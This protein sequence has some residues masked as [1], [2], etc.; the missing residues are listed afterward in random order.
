MYTLENPS[1]GS[2]TL[3]VQSTDAKWKLE[4]QGQS[5]VVFTPDSRYAIYK[6]RGD[7][8]A[9]LTLGNGA[10]EYISNA[11]NYQL[12]QKG[13]W[14]VYK[15]SAAEKT[16]VAY[17]LRSK[18]KR[19]FDRVNASWLSDDGETLLLQTSSKDRTHAL[20]VVS[21]K[22]KK[23][24]IIWEGNGIG[25][26]LYDGNEK[27][28]FI[29]D[30][31]QNGNIVK[32]IWDCNLQMEK[33]VP[34][35]QLTVPVL[36][37]DLKVAS[38]DRF[39]QSG[40]RLFIKLRE[41]KPFRPPL[42]PKPDAVKLTVWSYNDAILQSNQVGHSS[43]SSMIAGRNEEFLGVVD[44]EE[45]TLTRLE[46][47]SGE[48]TTSAT[49]EVFLTNGLKKGGDTFEQSWNAAIT[50]P[51]FLVFARDGE[52]KELKGFEEM[53]RPDISPA[54]K[55][56][57]YWNSRE[58]NFFTYEIATGI[59]RNITKNVSVRWISDFEDRVGQSPVG[60]AGWLAG[61]E[62]VLIYDQFD[63]WVIR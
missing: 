24:N 31:K 25:N 63:I 47:E 48:I 53:I 55:Y 49:D 59:T 36:S 29:A 60:P 32:S 52:R 1:V 3:I 12:P 28:A 30:E 37:K 35:I 22:N 50:R 58:K 41:D 51:L 61:D 11:Y 42:R 40:K 20:M 45:R 56:L 57:L 38:L 39:S 13:E 23:Q 26:V 18:E 6:M 34:V 5:G 9:F 15:L 21:L 19:T 2:S 33:A 8:L 17:N 43:A 10:I 62:A 44:L 14:M 54:E 27:I 7:S 16:V 4:L 46:K